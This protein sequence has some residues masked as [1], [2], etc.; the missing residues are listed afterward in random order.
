MDAMTDQ[1]RVALLE[2]DDDIAVL[3]GEILR[4]EG[5]DTLRADERTPLVTL[6]RYD[7]QLLLLDLLLADSHGS[8][9]LAALRRAGLGHVPVVLLSASSDLE[10]QAT[11]LGARA[12]ITKPFDIDQLVETCRQIAAA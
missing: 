3:L 2:D 5:F 4:D 8:D 12:F 1:P 11:R 9:V 7:P 6:V 10:Q